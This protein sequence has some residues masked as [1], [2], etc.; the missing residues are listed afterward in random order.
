[1]YERAVAC[2]ALSVVPTAGQTEWSAKPNMKLRA[3]IPEFAQVVHFD[4][5]ERRW[6]TDLLNFCVGTP[7]EENLGRGKRS[8]HRWS[9]NSWALRKCE[10]LRSVEAASLG[11]EKSG[12]EVPVTPP[13]AGSAIVG[14]LVVL[15]A[16][17]AA[18]AIATTPIGTEGNPKLLSFAFL[19][20]DAVPFL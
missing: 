2:A 19:L 10:K 16:A 5:R 11:K 1:M 20:L 17:S 3:S 6:R 4:E 18:S 14:G 13:R 15:A 9:P 8:R 12:T 7:G